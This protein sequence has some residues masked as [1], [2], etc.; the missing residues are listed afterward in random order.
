MKSLPLGPGTSI[1][2]MITHFQGT[3]HGHGEFQI[4][5]QEGFQRKWPKNIQKVTTIYCRQ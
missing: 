5:H 3:G 4:L 1:G 2:C